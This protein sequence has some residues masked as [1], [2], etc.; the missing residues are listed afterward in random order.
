MVNR[1]I[2]VTIVAGVERKVPITIVYVSAPSKSAFK[3][4]SATARA[5]D[6]LSVARWVGLRLVKTDAMGEKLQ[7][8]G[9]SVAGVWPAELDTDVVWF[10]NGLISK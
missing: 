7:G 4:A 6:K 1:N 2:Y 3:F 5:N 10:V 9:V 8:W